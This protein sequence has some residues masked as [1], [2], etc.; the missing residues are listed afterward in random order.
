MGGRGGERREK[1]WGWELSFYPSENPVNLFYH[2]VFYFLPLFP[3][4]YRF[5]MP[6]LDCYFKCNPMT[7]YFPS[8]RHLVLYLFIPLITYIHTFP[9]SSHFPPPASYP[10]KPLNFHHHAKF[11]L[12]FPIP[13]L[14]PIS[15]PLPLIHLYLNIAPSPFLYH[16]SV[17]FPHHFSS[18]FCCFYSS[19]FPFIFSSFLLLILSPLPFPFP[20]PFPLTPSPS[21]TP[22]PKSLQS[23]FTCPSAP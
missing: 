22:P 11:S 18:Y 8:I 14:F 10:P 1:G 19:F 13:S 5:S 21:P 6:L 23:P 4:F 3:L 20:F 2:W 17:F 7:S 9:F 12:L 16:Y 15:L